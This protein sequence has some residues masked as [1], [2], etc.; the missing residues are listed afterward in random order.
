MIYYHFFLQIPEWLHKSIHGKSVDGVSPQ[1]ALILATVVIG[2][3]I[4]HIVHFLLKKTSNERPLKLKI[5]YLEQKLFVAQN[6]AKIIK[7]EMDQ[8]RTEKSLQLKEQVRS[9][10]ETCFTA[11]ILK[12]LFKLYFVRMIISWKCTLTDEL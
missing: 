7:R 11:V 10:C 9:N 12:V 5:A 8:L 3:V 1:L 2:F 6:E 4:L